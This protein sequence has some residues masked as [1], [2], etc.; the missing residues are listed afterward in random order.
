[1]KMRI[2]KTLQTWGLALSLLCAGAATAYA[3]VAESVIG[4][5]QLVSIGTFASA[6]HVDYGKRTLVGG[7]VYVDLNLNPYWG[8]EGEARWLNFHELASANAAT[9]LGGPRYTF[10][11]V[12]HLR[13]YV[14]F[15]V[16]DGTFNFPYGY[17]KGN[18]IVL[19]PGGGIDYR[20]RHNWRARLV[21]VEYQKW[22]WFTFGSMSSYG[23]SS[24]ISYNF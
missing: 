18:Y 23:V 19:A 21:D 24:G 14:K 3:Q 2:R 4:G 8:V 5:E 9:Y 20:F 17:A 12:H 1:M 10:H 13:P 15:L 6:Y 16:G 22:P 11:V 7:G